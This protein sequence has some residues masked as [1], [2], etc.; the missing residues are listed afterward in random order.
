[1]KFTIFA[2]NSSLLGALRLQIH[3]KEKKLK[4]SSTNV[5]Q[6]QIEPLS[7][8]AVLENMGVITKQVGFL[9]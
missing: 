3:Q 9:P 8:K 5:L 4:T 2:N 7:T 6:Q 1:M